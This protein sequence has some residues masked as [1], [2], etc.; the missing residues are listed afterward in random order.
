MLFRFFTNIKKQNIPLKLSSGFLLV[1]VLLTA[2]SDNSAS[3][4]MLDERLRGTVSIDGSSTVF[5]ISEAVAEEF[6]K[7]EPQVRVTVG[8]S[9]TGGGFE[10]FI[11]DEIDIIDASR[12]IWDIEKTKAESNQIDFLEIPI[13]YD[14]LSV[15]VNI[16]N[17]WVDQLTMEELR[18][19]WGPNSVVDS[20][21]DIRSEWPDLPVNLYGPG[22]DSGTFEYFTE[23]VNGAPSR[24]RS[25]FTASEN[26]NILVQGISG[27]PYSLGYFGFA[28]YTANKN[29]LKIVPIDSG[30]G[31][32]APSVGSIE[33]GTYGP[34][35]R[36][37]YIYLKKSS[38]VDPSVRAFTN[39]YIDQVEVLS[40]EVGY[41]PLPDSYYQA[42]KEALADF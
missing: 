21:N 37:M 13:A 33:D 4:S 22:A 14:G 7:V 29:R 20:W 12:P 24:S 36:L 25:D 18:L 23:V 32:V 8:V 35:T 41:V 11:A 10:K 6:L 19:I 15:V 38:A 39:F 26:D 2:C 17:D 31:P 42:A 34:L 28:Y 27:D 30:S 3:S 9:G 40:R 5:P 1:L 16:N